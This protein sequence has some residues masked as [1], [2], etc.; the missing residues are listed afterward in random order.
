[1][2]PATIPTFI[3]VKQLYVACDMTR[4]I[5]YMQDDAPLHFFPLQDSELSMME[6]EVDMSTKLR[7]KRRKY[8]AVRL[9][10]SDAFRWRIMG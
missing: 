6:P 4:L 7:M 1:M 5:K 3:F 10:N 8:V 2:G 9:I